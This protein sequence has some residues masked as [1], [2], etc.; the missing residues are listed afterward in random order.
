MQYIKTNTKLNLLLNRNLKNFITFNFQFYA[1][2][3]PRQIEIL[4]S[5]VFEV[6]CYLV[7]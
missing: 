3:L 6:S 1:D 2:L 5:L 4:V 7:S